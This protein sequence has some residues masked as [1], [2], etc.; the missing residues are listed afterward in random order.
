MTRHYTVF[1]F[2]DVEPEVHGPFASPD[3]RDAKSLEIRREQGIDGGGI[4]WADVS[5]SGEL[6]IGAYTGGFLDDAES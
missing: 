4:Y 2:G 5:P 6:E 1:V 3:E